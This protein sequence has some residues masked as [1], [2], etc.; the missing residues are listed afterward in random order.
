[1]WKLYKI[2]KRV[3]GALVKRQERLPFGG[4]WTRAE[5]MGSH[6]GCKSGTPRNLL[7]ISRWRARGTQ[8]VKR[9]PSAAMQ[10]TRVWPLGLGRSSGGGNG[11]PLQC[12]CQENPLDRG[13][14][15][16]KV[17]GVRRAGHPFLGEVRTSEVWN[18]E[19]W[20]LSSSTNKPLFSIPVTTHKKKSRVRS[21]AITHLEYHLLWCLQLGCVLGLQLTWLCCHDRPLVTPSLTQLGV[22][23]T[24][25]TGQEPV[26]IRKGR[27]RSSTPTGRPIPSRRRRRWGCTQLL[28]PNVA[29]PP[30]GK[31]EGGREVGLTSSLHRE[32]SCMGLKTPSEDPKTFRRGKDAILINMSNRSAHISQEIMLLIKTHVMNYEL[33]VILL[34]TCGV[35]KKWPYLKHIASFWN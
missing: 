11:N 20:G 24:P 28:R 18:G 25:H 14:W 33:F 7:Y 13:A 5:D 3:L 17:H 12:S 22:H 23:R 15:W 21:V 9:P 26:A 16:A 6:P 8:Q 10:Q 30:T 31:K 29:F 32:L 2:Y 34:I 27:S 19:Y 1:M 35:K 4:I